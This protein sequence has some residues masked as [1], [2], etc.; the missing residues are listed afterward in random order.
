MSFLISAA[1]D[2]MAALIFAIF[3]SGKV[4]KWAQAKEK[5]VVQENFVCVEK[6]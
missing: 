1:L 2:A 4:Q 3:G 5:P 6:F